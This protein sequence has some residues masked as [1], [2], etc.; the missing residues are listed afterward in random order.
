MIKITY[1]LLTSASHHEKG[2]LLVSHQIDKLSSCN[3][4]GNFDGIRL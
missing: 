3:T 2:H 4:H 1:F